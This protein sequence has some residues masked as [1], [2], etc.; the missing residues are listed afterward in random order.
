LKKQ[1]A[2]LGSTGS[3]GRQTL[4]VI[5]WHRDMFSVE[6]LTA[7]SQADLLIQQ[8]Q[9]YRPNAV[10]IGDDRWYETVFE[11]L[12]PFDIK[13]YA[14]QKA[15]SQVLEMEGID[16]VVMAIVGIAGLEPTIAAVE[17]G[18]DLALANKES[19]VVAGEYIQKIIKGKT[20]RI[21]PID[22][23]HSAIFQC[24]M[25]EGNNPIEKIVL[26]CSGGPFR[27]HSLSDL[28]QVTPEEAL[29]H[30]VWNMGAKVSIDS[31]SLM[32]KGLEAIEA[33]WLFGLPA[34]Q[35][36]VV[37]HPQG[38]IHSLVYFTDGSVKTL[39][40]NPDMRLP[41][42][43]ALSYP[44]RL[45]NETER[46]DLPKLA[47]LDFE[48]PNVDIFRNLALAFEA[49]EKGGNMPCILNAAN[50]IAAGEFLKGNVKFLEIPGV[51]DN[52]MKHETFIKHPD[53]EALIET[54][55]RTRLRAQALIKQMI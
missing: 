42:Q 55:S 25:G 33:S 7:N 54:D 22:S 2:I 4:E 32:N 16:L 24:L 29:K 37:V 10:V 19:L 3:I 12:D 39:L 21:I 11:A 28:E 31:A 27:N 40:G 35:I 41:I 17:Q 34:S 49:L 46:V 5:D 20:N 13:V 9:Q 18:V 43:F 47:S 6:I 44:E 48:R 38:V 26:T 15:I 1:I 8:A 36:E 50:E 30:P 53:L 52:C 45:P 14:G 51:V 23:E